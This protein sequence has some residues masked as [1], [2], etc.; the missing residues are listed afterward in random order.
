MVRADLNDNDARMARQTA[1]Y[2]ALRTVLQGLLVGIV[3]VSLVLLYLQGQEIQ[4]QGAGAVRARQVLLEQSHEI[5]TLVQQQQRR[6]AARARES[7]DAVR[8]VGEQEK[9]LIDAQTA[10]RLAQSKEL[11]D[12]Q[13]IIILDA[14]RRSHQ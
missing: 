10:L 9:R 6:D 12:A 11:I 13:T 3:L 5:T 2:G 1:V 8:R 7:A 4:R 14:I